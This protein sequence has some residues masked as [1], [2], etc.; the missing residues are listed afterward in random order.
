[1][2]DFS[3]HDHSRL[4]CVCKQICNE[5]QESFFRRPLNCGSPNDLVTFVESRQRNTLDSITNLQLRLEEVEAGVMQP[6]L[7]KIVMGT[8]MPAHQHPYLVEIDRITR[9]LVMLPSVTRL[10]LLRPSDTNKTTPASIVV[11]GVL[12]WAAQ[13]YTKLQHLKVEIESCRL[14]SL[15]GFHE[16]R[17]LRIPGCSESGSVRTAD[18]LGKLGYLEE[19]EICGP[20]PGLQLRQKHAAYQSKIVQSAT[21]RVFEQ[22]KPLK[23]LRLSEVAHPDGKA[24]ALLT[25]KTVKA[26]YEIHKDSLRVLHISANDPPPE[27]FVA[28]ISAFLIA[29]P[30][31]QELRISWPK[32]E[33]SFVD[34]LPN[35]VRQLEMATSSPEKAQAIVDRLAVMKYRLRVLQR[36]KFSIINQPAEVQASGDKQDAMSFSPPIQ[37]LAAPIH[38]PWP[39]IWDVWH[40]LMHD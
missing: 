7:A 14:D 24:S 39:I 34:C 6:H 20:S 18:I 23:R 31:I 9:A 33:V 22:V 4:M 19:L 27:A 32:M 37:T 26:M 3:S 2:L 1:M 11:T 38:S 15:S 5:A 29:A 40:P 17:S 21:H 13:Y 28:Y 10:A 16:L 35:S 36:L 30:D 25:P 12:K 8:P